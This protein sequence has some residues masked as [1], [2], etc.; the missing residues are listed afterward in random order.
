MF[1]S[2]QEKLYGYAFVF[3]MYFVFFPGFNVTCTSLY[4]GSVTIQQTFGGLTYLETCVLVLFEELTIMY[5]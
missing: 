2:K 1:K 3:G 5:R 4:N